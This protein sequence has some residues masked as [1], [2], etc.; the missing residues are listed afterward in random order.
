M[1]G[2]MKKDFAM[3]KSNFKLLGVMF[4][5]F[6][7]MG[8][9]NKMDI[10]FILPFISVMIMIST[11]S[12]DHYNKW[13][14][15]SISLPNG[16]K[17]SVKSKYITTIFMTLIVSIITILLSF[18]ISYMNT[19]TINYEQT[20][21]SMLGSIFGTLLVFSF[22]YPAIYKFGVEKARI[23]IFVVV[24]GIAIVG[25]LLSQYI[26]FS[27]VT[28]SLTFLEDYLIIIL[29]VTGILMVY[30]SYKISERIYMKKEF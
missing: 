27:F 20:L 8:L 17:N 9:M 7:V 28:H 18:L 1:I 15:Y 23:G 21:I 14:A 16:R 22:M 2:F 25:G 11:F 12:Y 19:K 24:F 13:D 4:V 29:I 6:T 3:I 26:D 30:I 10:S 5:L